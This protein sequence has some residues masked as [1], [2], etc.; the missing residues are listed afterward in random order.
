MELAFESRELRNLCESFHAAKRAIGEHGAAL[1]IRRLADISASE[2]MAE[3]ME[4]GLNV[5]PDEAV[6]GR[7]AVRLGESHILI[8]A[9]GHLE[10]PTT[11]GLVDWAKVS[12]IRIIA[13]EKIHD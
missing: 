10:L 13:L 5:E 1:L 12:R 4:V 6:P 9:S 2:N 8:G 7:F 3:M 11:A